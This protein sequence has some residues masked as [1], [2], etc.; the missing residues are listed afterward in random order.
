VANSA[1]LKKQ[2]LSKRQR[3]SR[4][5]RVSVFTIGVVA[6]L[7]IG[8]VLVAASRRPNNA[9]AIGPYVKNSKGVA[10]NWRA[11]LGVNICGAWQPNGACPKQ[12]AKGD[13]VRVNEPA[14]YAGLHLGATNG[15]PDGIIHMQ[16]R[17]SD[18]AGQNATFGKFTEFAGW[19]VTGSSLSLWQGANGKTISEKNGDRCP[20]GKPGVLHW[21]VATHQR[22][23]T[24][25]FEASKHSIGSYKLF[26]NDVIV[27]YFEPAGTK[28]D[29]LGTVP[30]E[31]LLDTP[32]S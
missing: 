20:N 23:K 11:A 13:P 7:L 29:S 27:I 19:T 5:S 21:A 16:P 8:A 17:Q 4:I 18:E 10:D 25:K 6:L 1:K 31:L 15:S 14:V 12:N 24:T 22:G 28:I 26:D 9:G 2:A 3:P 30:S 32:V